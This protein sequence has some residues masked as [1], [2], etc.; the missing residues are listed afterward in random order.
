MLGDDEALATFVEWL[1]PRRASLQIVY[2][3]GRFFDEVAD[4]VETTD[5]PEP[6]A[7]ICGVGSE[8]RLFPSGDMLRIWHDRFARDWNADRVR[9]LVGELPGVVLQPDPCQ[10][11]L[12]ASF[13]LRDATSEQIDSVFETLWAESILPDVVYSSE[14]DLDIL[15]AGVNKG[16]ASSFLASLWRIPYDQVIVSGDSGNDRTLYEQGFRGIVIANAHQ[17]IREQAG[18]MVYHAT[19]A[20]AAGVQEGLEYWLARI[21][22]AP[23]AIGG[24]RARSWADFSLPDAAWVPEDELES[25]S[26]C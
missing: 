26:A 13:F 18:R 21:P 4:L 2:A 14:R 22:A 15:P 17:E 19:Q 10:S 7:V 24:P 6:D 1:G 20:R 9:E 25:L 16:A 8:I 3:T 12:K 23:V 11:D 5:L